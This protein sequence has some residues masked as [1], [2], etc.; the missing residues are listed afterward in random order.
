MGRHPYFAWA[1]VAALVSIC[2]SLVSLAFNHHGDMTNA[3]SVGSLF[4]EREGVADLIRGSR[5]TIHSREGFDGQFFLALGHDPLLLKP[6]TFNALDAPHFRARRIF[7]P[8]VARLIENRRTSVPFGMLVT[9]YMSLLFLALTGAA[10]LRQ[11]KLNP[12]F[13][14]SLVISFSLVHTLE[15][16]TSEALASL[17]VLI[18]LYCYVNE[19]W[20]IAWLGVALAILTKEISAIVLIAIVTAEALKG[21]WKRALLL[22]TAA[23]PFLL[24]IFYV[25]IQFPGSPSLL[26]GAQN[27]KLPFVGL[28]STCIADSARCLSGKDMF[29]NALR[30]LMRLWL[31]FASLYAFYS[32]H[33]QRSAAAIFASLA[34][35]LAVT[36]TSGP[37][38]YAYDVVR[39]FGRQL[40]LLPLGIFWLFAE[41]NKK[42]SAYLLVSFLLLSI[43]NHYLIMA[44]RISF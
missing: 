18:A 6:A 17:F 10:Y 25:S 4:H 41:D 30:V 29:I 15:T 31:L 14:F 13:I 2:S 37:K 26:N 42:Q 44:G 12:L 9:Q 40:Y 19:R 23:L 28:V 24:W 22:A 36:L 35:L 16:F 20:W 38:T 5:P 33:K 3:I 21:Q 7:F 1:L 11:R 32:L 27:L 43:A 39:N 34:A 8:V